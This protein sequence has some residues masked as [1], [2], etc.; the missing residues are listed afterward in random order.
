MWAQSRARQSKIKEHVIYVKNLGADI[1]EKALRDTF[2]AFG[3]IVS[4]T[5]SPAERHET[6]ATA[7]IVFDTEDA[8]KK[9][10][11]MVNDSF[12][13][14]Q[15][16]FASCK[17]FETGSLSEEEGRPPRTNLYVRVLDAGITEKELKCLFEQYGPISSMF[18]HLDQVAASKGYGF[19]TFMESESA[20]K[21]IKHLNSKDSGDPRIYVSYALKNENRDR[22][23]HKAQNKT[24][25]IMPQGK[26]ELYIR[27]IDA[28]LDEVSIKKE[29]E[30]IVDV[31]QIRIVKQRKHE[32]SKRYGFVTVASNEDA[33]KLISSMDGKPLK[34]KPIHISFAHSNYQH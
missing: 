14:G 17:P 31:Y 18:F 20:A 30:K 22:A 28:S 2:S 11:Q 19:V 5:L 12:W 27:N 26:R 3:S 24:E 13:N 33:E 21:A 10:I 25:S 4:C 6:R 9:A 15:Q 34:S 1:G 8:A 7:S 23:N 16:I 32:L 29:F